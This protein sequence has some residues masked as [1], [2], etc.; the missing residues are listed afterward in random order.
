M[1]RQAF[2]TLTVVL[3]A[4]AVS[5]PAGDARGQ[6]LILRRPT[7]ELVV[8]YDGQRSTAPDAP[9][10][11]NQVVREWLAVQLRGAIY[12]PGLLSFDLNLRPA[13]SQLSW[14][15]AD[16][17]QTGNRDDLYGSASVRL[18]SRSP[19]SFTAQGYRSQQNFTG[20]FD[21]RSDSEGSGYLFGGS[22]RNPYLSLTARYQRNEADVL[23]TSPGTEA[24]RRFQRTRQALV[25]AQNSKTRITLD[26]FELDDL[27]RPNDY[28][29][30]RLLASN[31][32]RWG[33]GSSLVSSFQYWDQEGTG[34]AEVFV[35]DQAVLLRHTRDVST[36]IRY[37]LTDQQTPN[38]F[39]RGWTAGLTESV[40][41]SRSLS[42]SLAGRG[43]SRKSQ[44]G[45]FQN[46]YVDGTVAGSTT[47]PGRF[48]LAG[49]V[50]GGYRWR[51]QQTGAG[52]VATVIGEQH[53]VGPSRRFL[54]D[55]LQAD[56]ASVRATSEDA[57]V[58]YERGLDYRLFRSGVFIEFVALPGGRIETGSVVLLDYR[59]NLL[60]S[61]SGEAVRVIYS[62]DLSRGGFRAYHRNTMELPTEEDPIPL[63]SDSRQTVTGVGL[64]TATPVGL[65]DFG[66]EWS[67]NRIQPVESNV[68]LVRG[69]LG[70]ALD[71]RWRGRLE[72][73]WSSRR[74]GARY[75]ILEGSSYLEWA[76]QPR[77]RLFGELSGYDWTQEA[78]EAPIELRGR[79]V[80]VG[81]GAEWKPGL[82]TLAI[83]YDRLHWDESTNLAQD[84]LF[85]SLA[86]RF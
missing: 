77:L 78:S 64:Q 25:T 62:L 70:L 12:S 13:L 66:A 20:T 67:Y 4:L 60:P 2:S 79:F 76:P 7:G 26:R 42:A 15:F 65:A 71:R 17:H 38:D 54:L 1:S 18:L 29:R 19:L 73:R 72:A 59:Y 49:S 86:R 5:L 22:F 46:Y 37:S 16:E 11:T 10:A 47:I 21:T 51:E 30:D 82:L 6:G 32:Q 35:W 53:E 41:L 57:T 31:R 58:L 45:R 43:D 74:N 39:N 44:L 68:Y 3:A 14:D 23:T 36:S 9:T 63:F 48:R 33:K 28:R 81:V 83:R 84:R 52:G 34:T 56:P 61:A 8:G 75:D 55:Q 69:G 50:G 85:A 40:R 80:G 27:L 24:T